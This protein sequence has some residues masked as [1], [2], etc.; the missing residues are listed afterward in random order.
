VR[1]Y[2]YGTEISHPYI[3]LIFLQNDLKYNFSFLPGSGAY[4]YDQENSKKGNEGY[5]VLKRREN[6]WAADHIKNLGKYN[7]DKIK[8]I[9]IEDENQQ[10]IS[11]MNGDYD[12]YPWSRAQW[13]VERFNDEKYGEIKN[14]WVQNP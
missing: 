4:V 8:F 6:Y 9:F 14:G 13:W 10:V 5:I 12:I 1:F 7:Y 11:F 3:F 2:K